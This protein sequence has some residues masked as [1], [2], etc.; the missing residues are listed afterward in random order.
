MEGPAQSP[1]LNPVKNLWGDVK[2]KLF[3]R[4]NLEMQ[5]NGGMLSNH[6]GLQYLLIGARSWP[7]P[8][9]TVKQF[10]ET[11]VIQLD[12]SLVIVV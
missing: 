11:V 7:T 2:K 12:V 8:C 3:L 6:P 5:R 10:S 4:Q 1:D 9:N